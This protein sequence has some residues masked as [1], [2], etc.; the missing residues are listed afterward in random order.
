[1]STLSLSSGQKQLFCL[2]RALLRRDH[3]PILVLDEA[4]SNLDSQT[5]ALMQKVIRE[6]WKDH[7]VIAVAHRLG[8]VIDFDKVAVLDNGHMVE[9]D[10]PK[11]LMEREGG[12]FR[13]LWNSQL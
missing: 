6:Q 9:F 13:G 12:V 2:A 3:S 5:D 1:M 7:T 10:T 8:S 4:T 11:K